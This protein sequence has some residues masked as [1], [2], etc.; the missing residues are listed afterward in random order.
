MAKKYNSFTGI[1]GFYYMPLNTEK[2]LGGK[3]PERIKYLQEIQVSKEQSIE[4]AYGDNSVAELAV[5][6]GTVELESTFHHLP[7]EDR[8]VLFGLDK[9]DDGVIG[10]GNNTPPY[11]AVIF[12]KT[13]ETG[14]SEYVGLLKGMFT[15]PELSG[16]TKE[17]GVEFSQDKSTAEF[18]PSEVEGFDNEQTMLLGRDEKGVTVMRD[19]IWKKVFGKEHPNKSVSED[20]GSDDLSA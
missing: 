9:S 20:L 3:D 19:A 13:T 17:D 16:Q 12:E 6:N 8:E 7:L 15:F 1:T 10:V 4:K 5:S 2:V 18:M 14:A 11:V